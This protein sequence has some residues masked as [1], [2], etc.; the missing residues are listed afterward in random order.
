MQTDRCGNILDRNVQKEAEKKIEYKRVWIEMKRMWN[1]KCK[2][3]PLI[4]R[5]TRIVT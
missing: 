2:I 3:I 1:L 4:I 5:A